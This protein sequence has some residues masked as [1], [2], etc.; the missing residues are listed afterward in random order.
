[1]N[2]YTVDMTETF[3]VILKPMDEAEEVAQNI[4]TILSTPIGSAPLARDIG[5][6]YSIV[7]EPYQIARAR[8]IGEIFTVIPEQEPRARVLEVSFNGSITNALTG[9]LAA[10]VRYTLVREGE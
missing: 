1:M 7:D 9:R 6:D 8:M 4:R 2:T 5:I 3:R 10:V